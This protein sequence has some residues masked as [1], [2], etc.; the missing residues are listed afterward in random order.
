LPAGPSS[1]NTIRQLTP[2][3]L[4]YTVTED[5]VPFRSEFLEVVEV[6]RTYLDGFFMNSYEETEGGQ[7]EDFLTV[8]IGS[9]FDFGRPIL[10]SFESSAVFQAST[11]TIPNVSALDRTLSSAL[12][13][14]NLNGFIGMLQSLPRQNVF[15]TTIFVNKTVPGTV[16]VSFEATTAQRPEETSVPRLLARA[17]AG[18]ATIAMVLAV[19]VVFTRR[20][21]SQDA[22][23]IEFE[24]KN[25]TVN[26]EENTVATSS[27]SQESLSPPEENADKIGHEETRNHRPWP[28]WGT[29]RR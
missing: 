4:E 22:K 5:R 24:I 10:I 2:Y 15:S 9:S 28:T 6:T 13:G 16:S 17:A 14:E 26:C 23:N 8:F 21:V 29:V 20:Q 18:T 1:G 7:I 25:I 11:S 27:S 3:G 19:V 12:R